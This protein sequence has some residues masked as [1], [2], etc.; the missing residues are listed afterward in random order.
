VELKVYDNDAN[1]VFQQKKT[2]HKY[3]MLISRIFQSN[4]SDMCHK[5]VTQRD[6]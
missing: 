4:T 5:L 1:E 2:I 3:V 6:N